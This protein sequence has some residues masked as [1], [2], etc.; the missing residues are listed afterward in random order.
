MQDLWETLQ[1]SWM[2]TQNSGGLEQFLEQIIFL[3]WKE[4]LTIESYN[5]FSQYIKLV[6]NI[7]DNLTSHDMKH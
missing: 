2:Q 4:I 1:S 7:K 6:Q 3:V 5:M